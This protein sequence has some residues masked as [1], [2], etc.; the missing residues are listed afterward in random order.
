[1]QTLKPDRQATR[2]LIPYRGTAGAASCRTTLPY[3]LTP[4][5]DVDSDG[6]ASTGDTL[7]ASCRPL[8]QGKTTQIRA[9]VY[10]SAYWEKDPTPKRLTLG[11]KY[12]YLAFRQMQPCLLP[13]EAW[14]DR[15]EGG[16]VR[17]DLFSNRSVPHPTDSL[18]SPHVKPPDVIL[19]PHTTPIPSSFYRGLDVLPIP[20]K[21]QSRG[22]SSSSS[23]FL[24]SLTTGIAWAQ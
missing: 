6:S 24:I 12:Q 14:R 11:S 2:C 20:A 5:L 8:A 7:L 18:P 16:F 23:T 1:M 10:H 13:C 9:P 15:L 22:K 3:I 21:F 4:S 19:R 17:K